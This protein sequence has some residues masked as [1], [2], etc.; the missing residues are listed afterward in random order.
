M[1]MLDIFIGILIGLA[2]GAISFAL[3]LYL[4]PRML[5]R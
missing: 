2:I 4:Y 1:H 5:K 3:M